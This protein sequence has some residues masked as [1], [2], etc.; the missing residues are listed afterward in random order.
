M[1]LGNYFHN[2]NKD[3]KNISF[4]GISFDTKTIKKNHIFFAIRGNNIDGNKFIP[5][6]IK[7]GSKIIVTE[8]KVK[9]I[10]N[11]IFF[12]HTKNVRKLLAEISF[13]IYN[14][15]PRNLIAV[16]GTNGKSSVTDFYYQILKLNNKKVASIGTLGVKSKNLNLNLSN[17]T[18]DPIKLAQILTK[19]KNQKIENIIMEASS[20][21]L[22]QNRLD[23]L[24]FS[25]GIFTNLSQ[26]HLDYHK[27]LKNY[28][29]AKLY[30]FEQLIK[31][32]GNIIT[33]ESI[34]EFK[35][36]KKIASIRN[37][38]LFSL[39]DK[40]NNFQLL[41]HKFEGEFQLLDIKY[42]KS[43]HK[44]K[45]NLIG[46]VQLKNMLMAIIASIKSN[47][48]IKEIFNVLPKIKSVNGRFEKIGKIKNNSKVILDYAHT[49]DALKTCLKNLKEQFSAHKVSLV[50][51]CGGNRDQNKRSKMGKIADLYSDKIYLTDDN[52]RLEQPDKIR[53]DI[54]KGIKKQKI[55]EFT[56]RSKAIS[57]AIKDLN[58]GEI[59]LVAGKGHE[60]IQEIG[61]KKIFSSDK[62]IILKAIKTKNLILS[63]N[64]RANIINELSG[65]KKI[66]PK[67]LLKH[68][69]IN[70]QEINKRDIFFAIKGKKM[71][72]TNL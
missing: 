67:V 55:F 10:Q 12:I 36:I 61:K 39:I 44:I 19:L 48:S 3:Y 7:K 13:K 15:H 32:D 45:L 71:M 54:K 38:K 40:K 52:P 17:T 62:K 57:E 1:L 63:K 9:K 33:D 72:V 23:G 68:G 46:K 24:K 69:R 58:T 20:H 70:S 42:K 50:F 47:I 65:E 22:K 18:I 16:T 64:L 66:S 35:K 49:P 11:G 29:K 60:T 27:N 30:L 51:G 8:R 4:T 37:L 28:L 34:P 26:D 14:K 31:K 2:I 21:G 53:K 6:A 59:L 5:L 41:S 25:S 43:I 56:N